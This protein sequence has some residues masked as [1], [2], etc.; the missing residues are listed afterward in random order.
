MDKINIGIVVAEFNYDIT[1]MMLQR[2][3][4]YAEFLG[5]NVS[6]VFRVPGTFDMP[7]AIKKTFET[8]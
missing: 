7:L 3:R 2:A 8:R 1:M 6:R 4:E 5:V